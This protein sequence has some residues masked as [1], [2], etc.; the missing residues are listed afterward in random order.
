MCATD[1]AQDADAVDDEE[2]PSAPDTKPK[3][4]APRSRGGAS[5]RAGEAAPK[6]KRSRAAQYEESSSDESGSDASEEKAGS[7]ASGA[8]AAESSSDESSSDDDNPAL[9]SEARATSHTRGS[10][11]SESCCLPPTLSTRAKYEL[12]RIKARVSRATAA[13]R[14][15]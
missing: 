4:A 9:L 5:S 14:H 7:D 8:A 1:R 3:A 10:A 15:L 11:V 6:R 2:L 12:R 13:P